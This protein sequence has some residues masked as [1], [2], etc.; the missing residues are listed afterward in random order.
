M[1]EKKLTFLY[2]HWARNV[3]MSLLKIA[4]SVRYCFETVSWIL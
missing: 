2:S 1:S 4:K 3:N